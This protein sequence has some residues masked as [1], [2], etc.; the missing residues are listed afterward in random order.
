MAFGEDRISLLLSAVI[1][2]IVKVITE[3]LLNW[4]IS[5]LLLDELICSAF[6]WCLLSRTKTEFHSDPWK[7]HQSP[8]LLPAAAAS[9]AT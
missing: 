5:L 8:A 6:F 1:K 4:L 2:V 7:S 3:K 9:G